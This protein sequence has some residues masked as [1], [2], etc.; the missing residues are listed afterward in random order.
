MESNVF[1]TNNSQS[2]ND[3]SLG[4]MYG[5]VTAIILIVLS[6][7][8]HFSNL[9]YE[10]WTQY[11]VMGVYIVA[12]ILF[13]IAYSKQHNGN[14]TFGRVFGR[15]FRMIA[16]V[17][18]IMLAWSLISTFIFPDIKQKAIEIAREEMEK[19]NMDEDAIDKA[20]EFTGKF[21][22]MFM[23]MGVIFGYVFYGLLG[24]LIGSLVAKKNKYPTNNF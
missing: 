4:M 19:K 8:L 12:I 14:V 2:T 5:L 9:G 7:I 16:L 11:A 22:Y 17:T 15:A 23:T 20:L 6:L 18:I 21:F 13:C 24:A 1:E 10:S 3:K